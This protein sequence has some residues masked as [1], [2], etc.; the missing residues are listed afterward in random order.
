MKQIFL[1]L[2]FCAVYPFLNALETDLERLEQAD[3]LLQ[4]TLFENSLQSYRALLDQSHDDK[5]RLK[6]ARRLVE[7]HYL[8]KSYKEALNIGLGTDFYARR[9]DQDLEA[10]RLRGLY[11]LGLCH[12]NLGKHSEAASAFSSYLDSSTKLP[13]KSEHE[14]RVRLELGLIHLNQGDT[15]QA[16]D[17]LNLISYNSKRPSPYYQAQLCLAKIQLIEEAP[18]KAQTILEPLEKQIPGDDPLRYELAFLLGDTY[19]RL[20]NF[21]S[22]ILWLEKAQK[23]EAPWHSETL[24]RLGWAHLNAHHF[25]KAE[26]LFLLLMK[27]P[28]WH[29]RALLSLAQCY[30]A[31]SEP[32]KAE[33]L[34]ADFMESSSLEGQA[35]ALLLKARLTASYAER[36]KIYDLVTQPRYQETAGYNQGWYEKGLNAFREGLNQKGEEASRV[37]SLAEQAF[38]KTFHL[39]K[40]QPQAAVALK[41]Q[42]EALCR[43]GK[44]Q[45]SRQA[46]TLLQQNAALL[47]QLSDPEE[48]FYLH[49]LSVFHLSLDEK[50]AEAWETALLSLQDFEKR[51]PNGKKRAAVRFMK[52]QLAFH[53]RHLE[54]AEELFIR[55]AQD[56]PTEM[57]ES[58]LWAARCAEERGEKEKSK[59]YKSKIFEKYPNAPC[60]A[61]SYFTYYSYRDYVQGERA[62]VKHLQAMQTR[63]PQSPYLITAYYLIGMDEKRD[64]R[65]PE[66]KWIRKRNM[67][68][69]IEALQAAE[70]LF[71]TLYADKKIPAAETS[72]FLN[73]RYRATLERAL[74]NL[75]IAEESQGAKRRIF[76]QYAAEVFEQIRSSFLQDHPFTSFLPKEA[77]PSLLEESSYWLAQT[78][79][80]LEEDSLAEALFLEMLKQYEASQVSSGYYLSRVWYESGLIQMR[81]SQYQEALLHF[82]KAETAAQPHWISSDQKID[83]WIQ[84]SFS[85]RALG[86]L[87]Q[88]M[89][90]LSR[91]INDNSI[92]SQR[93]KAMYLR[94]EIYDLQGRHDLS[95]KQL[96]ATAKKGGEWALKAKQ[97]LNHD[98]NAP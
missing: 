68:A 14:E 10:D 86:N 69:S 12:S 4:A 84:Q 48:L 74:A 24:Y 56:Y 76:L 93:V 98:H 65:T 17:E 31:Q 63:F 77:Y 23:P 21:Q 82:S 46:L 96:E 57:T 36:E 79:I 13:F 15:A 25:Q 28:D 89:L 87:D 95:R 9:E 43:M 72:F 58:Y 83:L 61:E 59:I 66:G 41:F 11:F 80:K 32:Q 16:T 91:A 75:A 39:F 30:Q 8:L 67:N 29:E 45:A 19:G 47:S 2:F 51:Y 81:R 85:H 54:E 52:G 50:R 94:A 22:A 35:E 71:D 90:I 62:A 5:L 44:P 53:R 20:R 34:L 40:K 70:S 42:V 38:G 27:Q 7:N 55:L 60:A 37:F 97:R 92:S 49:S 26:E 6:I 64:R 33:R 78:Q 18:E 1:A 73:V 3:K 88:A